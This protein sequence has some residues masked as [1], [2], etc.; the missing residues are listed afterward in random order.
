MRSGGRCSNLKDFAARDAKNA[1]L[2]CGTCAPSSFSRIE[3]DAFR[4]AH[5]LIAQLWIFDSRV[6]S[7][8]K[9]FE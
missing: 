4:C 5:G 3:T 8:D 7:K 9:Q 6:A 1:S 2:V